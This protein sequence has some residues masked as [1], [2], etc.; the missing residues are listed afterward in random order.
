MWAPCL[1]AV[2]TRVKVRDAPVAA[3][4]GAST[5]GSQLLPLILQRL[6]PLGPFNRLLPSSFEK[7]SG[8]DAPH[9]VFPDCVGTF[10]SR[11]TKGV[12]IGMYCT[13]VEAPQGCR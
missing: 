13:T 5:L 9:V 1:T 8:K 2:C 12:R 4:S 3:G 6:G 7:I 11:R 10:R